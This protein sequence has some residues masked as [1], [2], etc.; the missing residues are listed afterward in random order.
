MLFWR[1]IVKKLLNYFTKAEIILWVSSVLMIVGSFIMS[2]GDGYLS[3]IASLIGITAL[4][5]C[6]KGN[7]I[8][9]VLMIIFCLMY[10]YISYTFSY[11]GEML[12]YA[13][14]S[15]PMATFSL[16]SWLRNPY[17]GNKAEVKVNKLKNNEHIF[18]AV[19]TV[20]VTIAFYFILKVFDTAN[21]IP[22]TL[23]V[24]TSFA[25]AYLTFRRSP[26]YALWYAANDIVLIVLWTLAALK[27]ISYVSVIM[28]FVTFL[29]NDIYGFVSWKKME[30][31]QSE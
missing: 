1:I 31:R 2:G 13:C 3:F 19:L 4:I 11:Y 14:M 24:T 21:L 15:L 26:Y 6:A 5:L 18:M 12:T 30:K 10:T 22:S 17:E 25:A 9:Q 23:S 29:A 28:C 16:V 7:P 27:D 8:A 20:A